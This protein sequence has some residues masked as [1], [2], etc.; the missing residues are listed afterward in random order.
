LQ[1]SFQNFILL[2]FWKFTMDLSE[3]GKCLFT[4]MQNV[5]SSHAPYQRIR[6]FTN[7]FHQDDQDTHFQNINFWQEMFSSKVYQILRILHS[8]NNEN[9]SKV[10][11]FNSPECMHL[12][13]STI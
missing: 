13:F 6:F 3:N 7:D 5:E 4:S 1:E 10:E 9:E 12:N 8:T 11:H 2:K